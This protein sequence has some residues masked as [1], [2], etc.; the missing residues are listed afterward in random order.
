M[1]EATGTILTA[2]EMGAHNTFQ[3]PERVKPTAFTEIPFDAEKGTT[4]LPTMS[5]CDCT[6]R[7]APKK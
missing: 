5:V 6:I 7:V 2:Q 4:V 3:D 1:S